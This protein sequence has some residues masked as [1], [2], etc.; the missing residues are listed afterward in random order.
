MVMGRSMSTLIILL[1]LLLSAAGSLEA[2][3]DAV[4]TAASVKTDRDPLSRHRTG[5]GM[6]VEFNGGTIEIGFKPVAGSTRAVLR[7]RC[8]AERC[9][10]NFRDPLLLVPITNAP[11]LRVKF[12]LVEG[13]LVSTTALSRVVHGSMLSFSLSGRRRTLQMR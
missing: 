1:I 6:I 13:E 5:D 10:S 3:V 8:A 4:P 9:G 11:H 12:R 7:F 2:G